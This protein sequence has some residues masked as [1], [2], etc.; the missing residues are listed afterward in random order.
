MYPFYYVDAFTDKPFEGNPC[1]VFPS[2]D[3]LEEGEMQKLAA[4]TNLPETAFVFSSDHADFK[5]RYF[6][7]RSEV[8]FAGHP[9]S[10]P[11]FCWPKKDMS[12]HREERPPFSL[13]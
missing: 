7:P 4:E 11:R 9:L 10:R 3:G 12:F 8:P 6:T 1:A 2:A 13:S 5:V